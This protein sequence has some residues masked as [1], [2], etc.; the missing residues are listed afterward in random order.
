[1]TE[2][3]EWNPTKNEPATGFDGC[4]NEAV[5]RAGTSVPNN[6][7][8]CEACAALPRFKRLKKR[9]LCPTQAPLPLGDAP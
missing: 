6:W 1:V 5:I 8:L 2:L 3:C 7:H 9:P 4:E